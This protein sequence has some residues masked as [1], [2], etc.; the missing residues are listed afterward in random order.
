LATGKD[1]L[2]EIARGESTVFRSWQL[3]NFDDQC[4]IVGLSKTGVFVMSGKV[5]YQKR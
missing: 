3:Y 1:E 4:I 5:R 2:I